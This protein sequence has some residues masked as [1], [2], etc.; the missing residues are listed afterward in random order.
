[1]SDLKQPLLASD[2]WPFILGGV[3]VLGLAIHYNWWW[4][5]LLCSLYFV[6]AVLLFRDPHREIPS[7]PLA[8]V[9]PVDGRV[10]EIRHVEEGLLLRP[11]TVVSISIHKSGA[12][13]TR[14][15]TE[16]KVLSLTDIDSGSR[17][18][19]TA[20]L[21][22]RTDED[23][24]VV[25]LMKCD[26]SYGLSALYPAV[27]EVRLGERVGQGERVGFNRLAQTCTLYLPP[28]VVLEVAVGQKVYA[29]ST[30]LAEYYRESNEEE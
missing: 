19:E 5:V 10:S 14:S 24:D 21:W 4:L 13:T 12:Y 7:I 6:L 2:G 22:I 18:V 16:G 9:S 30:V 29:G 28:D 27:S 8:V 23:D 15:P 11:A 3:A 17:A 20:G 26:N 1:M 25:M